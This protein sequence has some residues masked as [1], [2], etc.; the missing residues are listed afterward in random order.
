ML[1]CVDRLLD[2]RPTI[3]LDIFISGKDELLTIVAY[4]I[5]I[6]SYREAL[7]IC[8]VNSFHAKLGIF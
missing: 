7:R 8:H 2:E 1:W 4:T 6:A 3:V 5:F